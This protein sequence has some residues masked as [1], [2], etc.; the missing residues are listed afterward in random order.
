MS[1][2][3]KRMKESREVL[4]LTRSSLAKK[5]QVTPAAVTQIEQ[6]SREP[7]LETLKK[8]AK[9]LQVEVSYLIGEDFEPIEAQ[10]LFRNLKG[11]NNKDKSFLLEL[12]NRLKK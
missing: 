12:Y 9:T 8:L 5:S 11:L 10:V 3:S 4:G 7:S 6:G 2:L 1:K